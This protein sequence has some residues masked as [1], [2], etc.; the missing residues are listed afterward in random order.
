MSENNQKSLWTESRSIRLSKVMV[1]LFAAAMVLCDVFG[2]KLVQLLLYAAGGAGHWVPW[3]GGYALLACLYLCS[4][5][6]YV[7]LYSMN[8]LLNNIQQEKVFLAENV[9][10]LRRVS[11][12]CLSAAVVCM[13]GAL[14]FPSLLIVV[15]A[16][17][18]VGLIVRIVKNVFEQA[19]RMKDELDFTV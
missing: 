17:S 19:I 2:W 6:A 10:L 15:L 5:P 7:L 14:F 13:A 3:Q 18:F 9:V 16:A 12:C 1:Y 11:W 8:R 4:V